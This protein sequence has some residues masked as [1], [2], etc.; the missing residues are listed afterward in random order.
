[1]CDFV[2][3]TKKKKKKQQVTLKFA[4]VSGSNLVPASAY[5]RTFY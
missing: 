1:M 3:K 4:Q 2:I 5:S